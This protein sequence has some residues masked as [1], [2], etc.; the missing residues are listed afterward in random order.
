MKSMFVALGRLLPALGLALAG[1]AAAQDTPLLLNQA[2]ADQLASLDGMDLPTAEAVVALRSERGRFGSP[3]ELRV[4]PGMSEQRVASIRRGTAVDVQLP[5]GTAGQFGTVD[6]V[7]RQ[8]DHEPSVQQVHQWAMDYARVNPELVDR[9]M[10][11]ATGFAALPRLQLE[12]RVRDGWGQGFKYY[13][14]DGV[15]DEQDETV[16]D[17]LDDADRDQDRTVV[18]RATW[19]LDNLVMSSERIRAINESQDVVKLRDKVLDE[20]TRVYFERRRVQ[21]DL[22]LSPARDVATQTKDYLRLME[23]TANLDALTG[24]SFSQALVR[25]GG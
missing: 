11:A 12:G 16:F 25:S 4:I 2:T 22:L 15:I 13:T 1:P 7:L 23:L 18:V 10:A 9:W 8:F 20:V 5:A 21:V 6:D 14:E 24:G 17:V 3:E 19:D